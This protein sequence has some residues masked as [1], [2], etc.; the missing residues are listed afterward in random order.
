M[1][2]IIAPAGADVEA[3]VFEFARGRLQLYL[4]VPGRLIRYAAGKLSK[5]LAWR[6]RLKYVAELS[7]KP[8]EWSNC[9]HNF[10]RIIK[11]FLRGSG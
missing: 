3:R 6:I 4:S 1:R 7:L 10:S 11:A 8:L 2:G 9:Y 5:N